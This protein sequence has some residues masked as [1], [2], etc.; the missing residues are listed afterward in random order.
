MKQLCARLEES[1]ARQ[2]KITCAKKGITVQDAVKQALEKWLK[3]ND[4]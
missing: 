1:L 4:K 3:E 2:L